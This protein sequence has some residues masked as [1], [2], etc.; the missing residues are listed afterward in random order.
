MARPPKKAKTVEGFD[1]TWVSQ[2]NNA[3]TGPVPAAYVGKT[4]EE[5]WDSC[6]GCQLRP[7]VSK[8]MKFDAVV[9]YAWYSRQ[10]AGLAMAQKRA[11]GHPERNDVAWALENRR[12]DA[13]AVRLGTL[14][15]PSRA[16]RGPLLDAVATIRDAGLAILSYTHFWRDPENASLATFCMA[17]CDDLEQAAEA[18]A[19]GWR[20][21]V[22]LRVKKGEAPN[23]T[24][25][26]FAGGLGV[27]CPAQ[28][29]SAVNCNS[30]RMCDPQHP[31]WYAG[32]VQAI[33]FLD[34]SPRAGRAKGRALPT[35]ATN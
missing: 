29:K 15:D 13:Q 1:L 21:S 5:T 17:S 20:P 27:V 23:V 4:R 16:K 3:K 30:C 2:A 24:T 33:G 6:E 18:H 19:L 8:F 22:V 11:V 32:K 31:V 25:F 34:H 12:K 35:A 7:D 28:L 10:Q 26:S 14:G 9:C